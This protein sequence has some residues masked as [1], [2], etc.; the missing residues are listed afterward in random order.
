MKCISLGQWLWLAAVWIPFPILFLPFTMMKE[1]YDP[2]YINYTSPFVLMALFFYWP[3]GLLTLGVRIIIG[4]APSMTATH[5]AAF[6]Q[7]LILSYFIL[8]AGHKKAS[9]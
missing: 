5:V 4:H 6:L 1:D 9:R 2:W 3:S 7:S 8:K